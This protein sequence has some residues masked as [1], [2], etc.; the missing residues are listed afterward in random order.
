[1]I[2]RES[3]EFTRGG[4]SPLKSMGIGMTEVVRKRLLKGGIGQEELLKTKRDLEE[5]SKWTTGG[6]VNPK[7]GKELSDIFGKQF[8]EEY[9]TY[10]SDMNPAGNP[11]CRRFVKELIFQVRRN[12][13]FI[14]IQDV[15][16]AYVEFMEKYQN[17]PKWFDET[18]DALVYGVQMY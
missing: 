4:E 18:L 1:M 15:V 3:I 17:D 8:D 11:E 12:N 6:R 5:L 14:D 9:K 2:V 13:N 10:R 7:M 16:E